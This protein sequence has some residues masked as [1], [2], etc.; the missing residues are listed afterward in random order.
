MKVSTFWELMREQAN[1]AVRISGAH[2]SSWNGRYG[3]PIAASSETG[4]TANWDNTVSYN[5]RHVDEPLQDMFRNNRVQNQD[6]A[7]LRRYREALRI[8]L[9]ENVHMLSSENREHAHAERAFRYEPGVRPLE[10]CVTELYSHQ[11]RSPRPRPVSPAAGR[12]G[13][14]AAPGPAA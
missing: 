7:E 12:P 1:A 11:G 8:V 10:E 4:G 6:K 5:P 3:P 2:H 13:P 9:H 14:S